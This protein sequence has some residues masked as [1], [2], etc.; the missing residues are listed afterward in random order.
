MK[1]NIKY[2][3]ML[4]YV[5]A[6]MVMDTINRAF[7]G[8]VGH[9]SMTWGGATGRDLHIDVMLS[10]MAM[11]YRPTGF[12]ADTLFPIVEVDKQS[13][14]YLIFDRA[15]RTRV[16]DT[17]RAPGTQARRVTENV[18]SG[19]YF[20][21]NYALA[22]AAVMEDMMNADPMQLAIL[23][24]GKATYLLDKL[25]MDWEFRVAKMVCSGANVGSY[26]AP[27]SNWQ[28]GGAGTNGAPL[29]DV[30]QAIDNVQ[31]AT[32][33]APN[34]IVFGIDAWKSFRRDT[35]VRNLIF[36]VNNGGGYPSTVQAANLLGVDMVTVG[37]AY[38]NVGQEAA[39]ESLAS[40]WK[41]NVLVYF[42]PQ[43]PS[44]EQPSLGYAFRWAHDGLPNMQVE[45]HPFDTKTKSQDIEIGYYQAEKI[46]GA[47][48][49]FLL[50]NVNSNH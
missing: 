45:R 12:I 18:G 31:G 34:R 22:A 48:Y 28:T 30:N 49:G 15:D 32:G 39:P 25:L 6:L 16:E 19:N 2:L 13:N 3:L 35:T 41:D 24:N 40:V 11:G 20:A 7:A 9:M 47:S 5:S 14:L 17:T 21:T 36:G 26:A 1:T 33:V 46:T 10:Q 23:I 27:S 8:T 44:V 37:G 42:A 38:Q 43:T 29:K 50:P 4:V